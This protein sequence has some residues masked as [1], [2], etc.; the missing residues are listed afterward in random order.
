MILGLLV[1]PQCVKC[2]L[3]VMNR[4]E[5]VLGHWTPETF[6]FGNK[7][8]HFI[9][10]RLE[11]FINS[12]ITTTWLPSSILHAISFSA[13]EEETSWS[14]PRILCPKSALNLSLS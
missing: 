5:I 14:L 6:L 2:V 11:S 4:Y 1:C 8:L 3:Y 12:I 13:L 10:S 7:F 9:E